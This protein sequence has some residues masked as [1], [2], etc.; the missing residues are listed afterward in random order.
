MEG[1]R[2]IP[3]LRLVILPCILGLL[4]GAVWYYVFC[5]NHWWVSKEDK[6]VWLGL[7]SYASLFH[8]LFA[9]VALTSAGNGYAAMRQHKRDN[10]KK[11][12]QDRLRERIPLAFKMLLFALSVIVTSIALLMPFHTVFA[13]F[14]FVACTG[15]I[16]VLF[17]E[18]ATNLD[19]PVNGVWY[20]G[21]V[22]P[23]WLICEEESKCT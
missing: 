7:F 3:H 22:D 23:S 4:L 6:D 12:F 8:S 21:W 10:N 17:W 9:V 13:G 5:K 15:F 18:V 14:N 16:L 20:K 19:D 11:A 1:E 2:L